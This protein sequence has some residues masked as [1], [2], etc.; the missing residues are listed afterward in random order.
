MANELMEQKMTYMVAGEKVELTPNTVR[1]YLVS[2]NPEN[3][4]MEETV[5]FMQLCKFN[6]LNPWLKEAYCIKYGSSPA[7]MVVSKEAYLKRAEANEAYDGSEAGI[8]INGKNGIEKRVGTFHLK[9]ED[10]VGGW[11]H[12]WRKDRSHPVTV[13]VSFDEFAGRT[14]DGQLNSQWRSK[15]AT[16]IRKVALV[17]ALREAFPGNIGGMYAAEEATLQDQPQDIVVQ[18][19]VI[20]D[21]LPEQPAPKPARK[22]TPKPAPKPEPE[23][24]EDVDVEEMPFA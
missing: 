6:G 19:Q 1:R 24:I 3:V 9:D 17:Q 2:G 14:K 4:T 23:E 16:M 18:S 22:A 8:I 11:A 10:I 13:D 12:V 21:N 7:T 5:M 15:P 20:K